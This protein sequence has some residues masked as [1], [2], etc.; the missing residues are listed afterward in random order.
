MASGYTSAE[1][2]KIIQLSKEELRLREKI[3]G[4]YADYTQAVK[5]YRKIQKEIN[6]GEAEFKKLVDASGN[7]LS[8]LND[9]EYKRYQVLQRTLKSLKQQNDLIEEAIKKTNALKVVGSKMLADSIKFTANLPNLYFSG[10]DKIK[11]L[12]AMEKAIKTSALQMG[13]LSNQS[14]GFRNNIVQTAK[15]TNLI[16]VG[17][18]ELAKMQA[19]YG[20]ELGRNVIMSSEGLK[21]MAEMAVVTGLGAEGT[22]RMAADMENQGLSAQRTKDFIEGAL[23]SSHKMG[24]NATKVVKNI[25]SGIKLLNKYNFKDG[26]KGLEKMAQTVA[27]LGVSMDFATGM[28]DKLF[29]I[30]GAVDMS[31]QLQVMGGEWAKLADPFKLM[32]MARN[33]MEGLTEALGKAAES[34]VTFN[35]QKGEFVISGLEMHRLRKIAE[36]TGVS[37]EELAEAGKNAAKFTAIKKQLNFNI[38]DK[39]LAEFIASTAE[40]GENGEAKIM[41]DAKPKLIKDL[42]ASNEQALRKLMEETATMEKRA[43]ESQNFDEALAF[44]FNSMKVSLLPLVQVLNEKLLPKIEGVMARF[45]K[46]KWGDAIEKFAAIA[47]GFIGSIGEF[48]LEWPLVTASIVAATKIGGMLFDLGKWYLNGLALS[49]GFLLGSKGFGGMPGSTTQPPFIGPQPNPA[50]NVATLGRAG[51][52]AA[53]VGGAAAGVLGGTAIGGGG[54]GAMIGSGIG[55]AAG[56]LGYLIPGVGL[57]AGPALMALGGM[58]GGFIGGKIDEQNQ[59]NEPAGDTMSFAGTKSGYS[60]N[61]AITGPNG[62]TPIPDKESFVS[63]KKGGAIEN[64]LNNKASAVT[65]TKM[66]HSPIVISGEIKLTAPGNPDYLV[67]ITKNPVAMAELLK[68]IRYTSDVVGKGNGK[69]VG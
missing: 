26:V 18:E 4:S 60:K 27:K 65:N 39:E 59:I 50:R 64:M 47:G 16:G 58:A 66:E 24:L 15:K 53:G 12:L 54:T 2:T 52:I 20:E 8:T 22:S 63:M 38:Q 51:N 31:A 45:D 9:I 3:G 46:E 42:N 37:Y 44:T 62:I 17:V 34:A 23:N 67:D 25:G 10:V 19:S 43:K 36:Q 33:D 49:R 35:K 13:I 28:A 30:E 69:P 32:Y 57:L 48:I 55:T 5:D 1:L 40:I 41:L 6:K 11:G 61:R 56:A 14:A 7:P 29:D 21:G 68:N